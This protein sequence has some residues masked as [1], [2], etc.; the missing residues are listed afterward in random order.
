MRSVR[1]ILIVALG[2]TSAA[3]EAPRAQ[4]QETGFLDRAVTVGD[5][6]Y[7]YQVYV[8]LGYSRDHTWPVDVCTA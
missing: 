2:L 8:P 3:T 7:R 1:T 4:T 6:V 5:E